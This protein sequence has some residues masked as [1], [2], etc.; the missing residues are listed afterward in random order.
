ML[1]FLSGGLTKDSYQFTFIDSKFIIDII[2]IYSKF[3]DHI[4]YN[5]LNYFK[6]LLYITYDKNQLEKFVYLH[7]TII[8]AFQINSFIRLSKSLKNN[9]FLSFL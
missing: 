7:V 6:P 1:S 3:I 8:K 9:S 5:N 4:Y 2:D